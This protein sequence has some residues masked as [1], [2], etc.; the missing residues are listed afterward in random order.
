MKSILFVLIT[1]SIVMSQHIAEQG[2]MLNLNASQKE[3]SYLLGNGIIDMLVKDSVFWAG[4][5]YG[6]NKT[7]SW[8][9][10]WQ[11]FR[12]FQHKS[13]GGI[14]AMAY[15]N[16][17][18]IWI[19]TAFD[20]TANDQT[21][22]AGGGLSF[23]TDGGQTWTHRKQPVDSRNE[24]EYSPT[25]VSIQNIT[26]DIA[27]H[28][29]AVW[30]A[31]WAGG[32]RKTTD[33][34]KTWQVIT[35]DGQPFRAANGNEIHLAFSVL[36]ENENL[37]VGSA[38]GIGLSRDNGESFEVFIHKENELTISGNFVVALAYQQY[39]N[40]VWAATYQAV[41]A[42]EYKAVSKTTTNGVTWQTYLKDK[43]VHNFA[44]DGK[45]VYA[46]ADEGLFLTENGG[47]TWYELPPIKD[48]E[49]G[50]E[51]FS[52]ER[53]SLAVQNKGGLKRLWVGTGDGLAYT[54]DNGNNWHI[55]RSYKR[56]SERPNPKVYGYPSPFSP[57]RHYYMRFE[58]G[59]NKTVPVN[60]KI[61]D[62][63]MDLVRKIPNDGFQAK[64]D[65]RNE[66]GNIVASGVYSFR[67]E[68]NGKVTWGKI[69]VIN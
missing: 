31:S 33:M 20:T 32:L 12:E 13:K 3:D 11:T 8:G 34:G 50:E 15:T 29:N 47:E 68:I 63:A 40:A 54:D 10:K 4:T 66:A 37:W 53:Y 24:T 52:T 49:S 2:F 42:T 60:I 45:R 58:Y 18:T 14:A 17:N 62:Y 55:I 48:L 35:L 65:G 69:V 44:I 59:E 19:S 57:S 46:A 16:E 43:T 28:E 56:I 30:I 6:L 25:T 41:G 26:Y 36:S 51:I 7:E 27:G 22:I 1:C 23:S 67:A 5:G 38:G 39:D 9:E 61:Y 64:W 21:I